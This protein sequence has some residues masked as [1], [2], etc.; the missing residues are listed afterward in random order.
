[1][2]E[3]A[4]YK[5][6]KRTQLLYQDGRLLGPQNMTSLK[7]DLKQISIVE[8]ILYAVFSIGFDSF[9]E[10]NID[11]INEDLCLESLALAKM[12]LK[13]SDCSTTKNLIA[14]FCFHLARMPA[15]VVDNQLISFFNQDTSRWNHDFLNLGLRYLEKPDELHK[16]YLEAI[17]VSRHMTASTYDEKYWDEIIDLYTLLECITNS[18]V[19]KINLAFCL[20]KAGMHHQAL[21]KLESVE[22][23]LPEKHFY[24]SLVKAALLKKDNS[25]RANAILTRLI[26]QAR[27]QMR[28]D[29]LMTI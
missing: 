5:S 21:A 19:V 27:Q 18:P 28:Q 10:K 26:A 24:F 9:D 29:H 1:M 14:L 17:I 8:Q 11:L 2:G 13:V 15:K 6:I 25:Q 3:A 12:L 20:S 23:D 4:I 16:F 7:F 22:N